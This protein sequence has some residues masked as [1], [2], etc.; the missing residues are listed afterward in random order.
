MAIKPITSKNL[1][2][3][4][5]LPM[6]VCEHHTVISGNSEYLPPVPLGHIEPFDVTA[7]TP[8]P[9]SA[10][11]SGLGPQPTYPNSPS[12]LSF[13]E[14]VT[15]PNLLQ[16][17]LPSPS[18]TVPTHI[19]DNLVQPRVGKAA[20]LVLQNQ[21]VQQPT[22]YRDSGIR[23]DENGEKTASPSK[24]PDEVPPTYMSH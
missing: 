10:G 13:R 21:D 9:L 16:S 22:Q 24:S 3:N 14:V 2:R 17:V 15:S 8:P 11:F 23:F 4:T 6:K 12:N 7:T 5:S 18:Q 20:S 19:S 1:A